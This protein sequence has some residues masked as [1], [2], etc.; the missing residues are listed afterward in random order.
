MLHW[1]TPN[2]IEL[3]DVLVGLGGSSLLVATGLLGGDSTGEVASVR[4]AEKS[5][6]TGNGNLRRVSIRNRQG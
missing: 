5:G 1:A 2:L 6:S 3:N 4:G